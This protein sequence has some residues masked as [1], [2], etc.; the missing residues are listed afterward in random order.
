MHAMTSWIGC[1]IGA[2]ALS[3]LS[4]CALQCE[5][6]EA[7]SGGKC[8][9]KPLKRFND[10]AVVEYLDYTPDM[11][12]SIVGDNAALDVIRGTVNDQIA[13]TFKPFVWRAQDAS[14]AHIQDGWD[15]VTVNA[16]GTDTSIL[17]EVVSDVDVA[18]ADIIVELPAD[19]QGSVD[20]LNGSDGTALGDHD[21]TFKVSSATLTNLTLRNKVL[22]AN[23][24]FTA[25]ADVLDVTSR[26]DIVGTLS[27]VAD[28]ATG[29]ISADDNV[30]LSVPSDAIF[31]LQATAGETVDFGSPPG[32]CSVSEAAA[33][34]KTLSCNDA[35]GDSPAYSASAEDGTVS[36]DYN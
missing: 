5:E 4:G 29:D 34:S 22:G 6:N 21:L 15:E 35:D 3:S 16:T 11:A 13:V 25:A 1:L 7:E 31:V 33:N 23:V 27:G 32:E 26:G 14:D 24:E 2:V 30:S 17:V 8:I 20:A 9:A 28:G 10:D 36:V 18:S 12:V 19:F